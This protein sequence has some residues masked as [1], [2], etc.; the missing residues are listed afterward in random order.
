MIDIFNLRNERMRLLYALFFIIVVLIISTV[1]KNQL[2]IYNLKSYKDFLINL[3]QQS[4]IYSRLVFTTAFTV[5][6]ALSLP[7]A[8]FMAV[9]GGVLF[10]YSSVLLSILSTSLGSILAL[11]IGRY[12]LKNYIEKTFNN[13]IKEINIFLKTNSKLAIFTLRLSPIVPFYLS[14]LILCV[15]N[16]KLKDYII[17]GM[18]AKIPILFLLTM[19]GINLGKIN[20]MSDILTFEMLGLMAIVSIAPWFLS[21]I[22]KRFSKKRSIL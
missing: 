12:F 21:F 9:V 3:S 11:Y 17:Y 13:K 18:L 4:P 14:T 10:G 5:F 22:L 6:T 7:V 16:V 15:T 8:T 19:A 20:H 2:T 1:F